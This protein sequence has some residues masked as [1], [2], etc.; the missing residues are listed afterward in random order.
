M[1]SNEMLITNVVD[2]SSKGPYTTAKYCSR[3]CQVGHQA[4]HRALCKRYAAASATHAAS[5]KAIAAGVAAQ[6]KAAASGDDAYAENLADILAETREGMATTAAIVAETRD[7]IVAATARGEYDRGVRGGSSGGGGGGGRGGG[8]GGNG[9]NGGG[10][11]GGGGG[12]DTLASAAAAATPA[13]AT[14][15]TAAA[16]SISGRWAASAARADAIAG[17]PWSQL[18]VAMTDEISAR[19]GLRRAIRDAP[20]AHY[21]SINEDEF[22]FNN[23]DD[24]FIVINIQWEGDPLD[25][26]GAEELP[27]EVEVD[28]TNTGLKVG[29][30]R[31]T[32]G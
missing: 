28:I 6:D 17:S 22:D 12:S 9:G 16:A 31:L 21:T 11:G 4:K 3:E 29:R 19:G 8:G 23:L 20:N 18:E 32:P 24:K 30:C 14:A 26:M 15:S 5:A 13:T 2:D 10:G 7:A 27:L 1:F 25:E